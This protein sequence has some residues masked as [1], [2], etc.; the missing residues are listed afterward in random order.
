[1]TML[2]LILPIKSMAVDVQPLAIGAQAPDFS[3]PGIDGKN[4]S[5]KDFPSD[6]LVI[7]FTATHCPTAQAYE[8]R[9]IKFVDKYKTVSVVAIAPNAP[10][11]V[12]LEEMGYTDLGDTFEEMKIR[13]HEKKF[14]FPYLYDGDTQETVKAYGAQAT[15][16]VFIFDKARRLQYQGRFDDTENPYLTPKS[17]DAE[18]AVNALLAGEPVPVQQTKVF[19]CSIKWAEKAEWVAKLNADWEAKPVTVQPIDLAAIREL[20]KN[21]SE[22]LLLINVWATW[23]GPCVIEFPDLIKIHRMY[24]NRHFELVTLSADKPGAAQVAKFLQERH[25]AVRNYHTTTDN[26]YALIEAVD[27]Q[28]SGAL[29]YT[30]LVAPGGKILYRHTGIIDPLEIKQ[31]IVQQIGR[32]FADDK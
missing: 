20:V 21:S 27:P 23:C 8:E 24:Q 22:N 31:A 32:Y 16:H 5:L 19:G 26:S 14:N 29:P 30:L 9:L 7:V 28:W 2:L 10:G 11:A 25:A 13:A 3:L 18:N 4:Y 15:P 6:V 1:L 17:C 12:A